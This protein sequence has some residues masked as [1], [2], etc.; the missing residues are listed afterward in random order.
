MTVHHHHD[1]VGAMEKRRGGTRPKAQK[2]VAMV[3]RLDEDQRDAFHRWAA[4]EERSVAAHVRVVL[5]SAI[6]RE[7]FAPAKP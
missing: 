5:G 1:T 6:P 3:V 7:F 2:Q 4:A